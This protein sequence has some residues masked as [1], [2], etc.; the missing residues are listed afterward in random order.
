[1]FRLPSDDWLRR[2]PVI[3]ALFWA[4]TTFIAWC[5]AWRLPLANAG[6]EAA[7]TVLGLFALLV[8]IT[9]R[10][11]RL[12]M[13]VNPSTALRAGQSAS[14]SMLAQRELLWLGAWAGQVNVLG[15]I[16]LI[17]PSLASALPALLVT[18]TVEALLVRGAPGDWARAAAQLHARLLALADV[19]DEHDNTR[20]R[21]VSNAVLS[22]PLGEVEEHAWSRNSVEGR[23]E[24]GQSY[25]E[26]WVKF[27]LEVGQKVTTLTVGFSP[28]FQ[29]IPE[30]E[31]DQEI[32]SSDAISSESCESR[33]EHVTPS[34]MRVAVKRSHAERACRGKL[35]WHAS[36]TDQASNVKTAQ[37]HDRLP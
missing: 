16:G 1:M 34:G 33:L 23:S 27:D 6:E 35:L 29:T 5:L 9:L 7:L 28:T 12:N 15:I 30:V 3:G 21:D 31:L 25:L 13:L 10:F 14:N 32:D 4:A 22:S 17:G 24:S 18:A 36:A 11:P 2:W 8:S 26:G 19:N 37:L 20:P